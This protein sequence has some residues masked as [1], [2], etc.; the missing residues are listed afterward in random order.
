MRWLRNSL[1]NETT[2]DDISVNNT[3]LTCSSLTFEERFSIY[4]EILT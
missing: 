1:F 3:L 4:G 2:S